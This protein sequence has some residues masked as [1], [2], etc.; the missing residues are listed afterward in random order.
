MI[1]SATNSHR[2]EDGKNVTD[3][4]TYTKKQ[5]AAYP[6]T[7]WINVLQNDFAAR[8]D[9][10]VNNYA[11]ANHAPVVTLKG[12]KNISAKPGALIKLSGFA[13]DPDGN[14]VSFNWWQYEEVGT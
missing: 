6:Q 4:K 14:A 12:L 2:W 13:K 10:C 7:S 5:D 1:K 9:W 8:A 3:F 11:K